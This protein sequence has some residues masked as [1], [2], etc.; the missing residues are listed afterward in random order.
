MKPALSPTI[1]GVLSSERASSAASSTTSGSVTTVRMISTSFCT[2][3]GLKK[4]TPI[5]R[6]GWELAVEIS[7][8]ES[9]EVLVARIASGRTTSSRARKIFCLT[10]SC[11][12]TAS[13]TSPQSRTSATSV[14][15]VI[16]PTSS[17]CSC[18]DSLPRL[19]AR[20]VECST[21]SRPRLRPSSDTSTPTT[22]WPLRAKTSAMPAPIVPRPMTPTEE[23]SRVLLVMGLIMARSLAT[24]AVR[25][26]TTALHGQ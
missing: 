1:T 16:R 9:D 18:S 26:F 21:C 25:N 15:N 17:S 22:R 5:T 2:G 4:C 7:V 3:A 19:T 10:G 14:V 23:K 20:P 6:P 11:S 24:R 13:T 8:T 12:T